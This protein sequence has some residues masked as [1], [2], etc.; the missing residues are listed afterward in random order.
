M[1]HNTQKGGSY[2]TNMWSYINYGSNCATIVT[3]FYGNTLE[4]QQLTV[5]K[6]CQ[7]VNAMTQISLKGKFL[8]TGETQPSWGRQSQVSVSLSWASVSGPMA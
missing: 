5:I 3:L 6:S 1:V 2:K 4:I 7:Q 8:Y